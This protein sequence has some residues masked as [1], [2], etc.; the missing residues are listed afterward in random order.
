[1]N[2]YLVTFIETHR[3]VVRVKAENPFQ[4][5]DKYLQGHLIESM[6]ISTEPLDIMP[7][8]GH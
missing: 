1:M 7:E 5:R 4:A 6:I 3:K 8:P 2:S